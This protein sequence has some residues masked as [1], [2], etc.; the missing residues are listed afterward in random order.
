MGEVVWERDPRGLGACD[1][2]EAPEGTE[3]SEGI[4]SLRVGLG[5]EG[6]LGATQEVARF[7]G[8]GV[9]RRQA[10][11]GPTDVHTKSR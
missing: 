7:R 10:A 2:E 9:H 1:R 11:E 5:I 8:G 4:S 3:R 6:P